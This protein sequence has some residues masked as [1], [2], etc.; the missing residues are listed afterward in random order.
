M[1]EENHISEQIYSSAEILWNYL[2]MKHSLQKSDVVIAMGS[3][4]LRVASYAAHLVLEGLAPFLICSGGYGRL[5][6]DL[7]HQCEAVRFAAAAVEKV[8]PEI[9]FSLRTAQQTPGR[10]FYFP[11]PCA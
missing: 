8:Y 10:I 4:D 2:Q 11:N 6:R 1:L 9:R 5:T 7:W 3:H